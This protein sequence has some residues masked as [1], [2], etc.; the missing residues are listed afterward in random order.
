MNKTLAAIF[1]AI[2]IGTLALAGCGGGGTISS[3]PVDHSQAPAVGQ[4]QQLTAEGIAHRLGGTRYIGDNVAPATTQYAG[5]LSS[6]RFFIGDMVYMVKVFKT[7]EQL[8]AWLSEAKN[9]G[10]TP[11]WKGP[12]SAVIPVDSSFTGPVLPMP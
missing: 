3:K 8:N 12:T 11:K 1:A 7:P 6:G 9:L 4:V 2:I 5:E 10:F